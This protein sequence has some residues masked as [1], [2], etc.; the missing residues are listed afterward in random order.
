MK[1]A[2]TLIA[3]KAFAFRVTYGCGRRASTI[4]VKPGARFWVTSS[5][6][7]QQKDGFVCIARERQSLPYEYAFTPAQLAELFEESAT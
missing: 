6:T 4:Q 1:H 2:S 5:Q 3:R 7:K